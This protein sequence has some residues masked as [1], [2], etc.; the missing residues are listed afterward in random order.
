MTYHRCV[1]LLVCL[2]IYFYLFIIII[3][4]HTN[5]LE[6]STIKRI[7]EIPE[8]SGKYVEESWDDYINVADYHEHD[9]FPDLSLNFEGGL[10]IMDWFHCSPL[11][12]H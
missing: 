3:F 4:A 5:T 10:A 1:S 9:F 2:F 6:H 8:Y 11:P 7:K 12:I